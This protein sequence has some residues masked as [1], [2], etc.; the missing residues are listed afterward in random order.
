MDHAVSVRNHIDG[1]HRKHNSSVRGDQIGML[2]G[3]IIDAGDESVQ[4]FSKG[5]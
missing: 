4:I 3:V 1:C 2:A 5:G